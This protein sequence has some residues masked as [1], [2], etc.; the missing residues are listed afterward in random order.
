M[1]SLHHSVSHRLVLGVNAQA[2]GYTPRIGIM[3][4]GQRKVRGLQCGQLCWLASGRRGNTL[5]W[6]YA[7]S[8]KLGG[9]RAGL[10]FNMS[11]SAPCSRSYRPQGFDG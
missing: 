11:S 9:R 7:A 4:F 5:A 8:H 10:F 2:V 1:R 3:P 6:A